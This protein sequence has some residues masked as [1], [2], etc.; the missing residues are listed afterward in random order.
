MI[1]PNKYIRK[2]IIESLT[3]ATGVQFYDTAIPIDVEPLP[4]VYG[5]VKSQSKN[6]FGVTK[7]WHEWSCS[8]TIDLY[9]VEALG[10]NSNVIVDDLEQDVINTMA[11]LSVAGFDVKRVDFIDSV[12]M[13]TVTGAN[14]V[15][16]TV[17]VYEMWL[18]NVIV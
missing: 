15:S 10:F 11:V 1:N 4:N 6:R 7:Q 17:I 18:D 9:S 3:T 16:R 14:T 13:P 12:A 5:I 8:V 2:A